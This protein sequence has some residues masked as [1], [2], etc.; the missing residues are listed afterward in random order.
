MHCTS[1][2][3][4]PINDVDMMALKVMY[5]KF[6]SVG[7]SDHTEF[8]TVIPAMAVALGVHTYEKHF[9]LNKNA[10]GPDHKFALDPQELMATINIIRSAETAMGFG[11][12]SV[13][14]SEMPLHKFAH[15]YV[16]AIDDIR[17]GE[18]LILNDNIACLRPGNNQSGA[19]AR[20]TY[21]MNFKTAKR[22]IAKGQGVRLDDIE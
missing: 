18:T 6:G 2:Y 10:N 3:P 14:E 4:A 19:E 20:F 1:A 16:Q 9:T 12:K 17:K 13:K 7:Y 8:N 11:I 5:D 22:D 21:Y 15:R